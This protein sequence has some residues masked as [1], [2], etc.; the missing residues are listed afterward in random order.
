[1]SVFSEMQIR[2]DCY[3]HECS[4]T[5]DQDVEDLCTYL[6]VL[7]AEKE[8]LAS[9]RQACLKCDDL[10]SLRE[11]IRKLSDS[12]SGTYSLCEVDDSGKEEWVIKNPTCVS[13]NYWEACSHRFC[14]ELSLD[15]TRLQPKLSEFMVDISVKKTIDPEILFTATLLKRRLE[16]NVEVSIGEEKAKAQVELLRKKDINITPKAYVSLIKAKVPEPAI[17]IILKKGVSL[18]TEGTK[19]KLKTKSG[20]YNFE[21]LACDVTKLDASK[22]SFEL[23]QLG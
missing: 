9:G 2:R 5:V 3:G 14:G 22:I 12:C 11:R 7:E 6:E 21:D 23:K 18:Y 4:R 19:V 13:Y 8:A 10:R 15:I 1:M 17:G 20:E 16:T